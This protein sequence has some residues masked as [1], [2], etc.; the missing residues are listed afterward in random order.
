MGLLWLCVKSYL[1]DSAMFTDF[2]HQ[3]KRR[4]IMWKGQQRASYKIKFL[5]SLT[6]FKKTNRCK[7]KAA[8]SEIEHKILL[9]TS[10]TQSQSSL[11][12]QP[13]DGCNMQ[14]MKGEVEKKYMLYCNL[15]E[16]ISFTTLGHI[17]ID[18]PS[19]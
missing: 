16:N 17:F 15:W 13:S 19:S 6:F 14:C 9:K 10:R 1:W 3:V 5:L 18:L 11:R 2:F 7:S 8:V 12:L 4:K